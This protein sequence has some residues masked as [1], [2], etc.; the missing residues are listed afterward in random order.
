[1]T[2]LFDHLHVVFYTF[3]DAGSTQR[4]AE[5]V[6]VVD[7]LNEVVLYLAD[8]NLGLFLRRDEQVGGVDLIFVERHEVMIIDGVDFFDFLNFIVPPGDA[9]HILRIS[10]EDIHVVA[11]HPEGATLQVDVVAHVEGVDQLPQ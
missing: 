1:M 7:A 9:Q 2:Q 8:G 10:H 3:F 11:L 6:V 4:V 5:L